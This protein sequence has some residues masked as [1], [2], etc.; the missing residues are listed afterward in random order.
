MKQMEQPPTKDAPQAARASLLPSRRERGLSKALPPKCPQPD[1]KAGAP[2][3]LRVPR[4]RGP[5]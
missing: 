1:V 5:D 3:P 4:N 2:G